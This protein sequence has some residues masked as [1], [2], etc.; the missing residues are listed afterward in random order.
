MASPQS[1]PADTHQALQAA[2]VARLGQVMEQVWSLLDLGD[3]EGSLPRFV[4][5]LTAI[6]NR[7][8]LAAAAAADSFYRSQRATTGTEYPMPAVRVSAP[9]ELQVDEL[10][11]DS[12][13]TAV[14]DGPDAG[15]RTL[16]SEAEQLVQDQ[17]RRQVMS[18]AQLDRAA[19]GWARVV[20]PGACSFCLMLALRGPVYRS[21]RTGSFKAH[22]RKPN[23][24]GGDCRCH[25][26]P[27]FGKWE[28]QASVRD[29]QALWAQ[30]TKGRSGHDA[31]VAFRQAVEGRT[32]TGAKAKTAG[33]KSKPAPAG[34]DR[35][36]NPYVQVTPGRERKF[37][38]AQLRVLL[39]M[40]PAKTPEAAEWRADRISEIRTFLGEK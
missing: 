26:E 27:V 29:A 30:V 34:T 11:I 1:S 32:V 33:G 12:V 6:L 20:E 7:Y 35:H 8:G 31:R 15:E 21:Q 28:P 9:A 3:V 17:A 40:P 22:K 39:A 13:A 37:E 19:R 4:A 5:A 14:V 23:G 16:D 10:V 38:E 36:G 2:L 24:S 25:A 18:T